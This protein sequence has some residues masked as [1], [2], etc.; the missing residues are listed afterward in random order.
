MADHQ[1]HL[2]GPRPVT[3]QGLR[4]A[5][6]E[7]GLTVPSGRLILFCRNERPAFSGEWPDGGTFYLPTIYLVKGIVYGNCGHPNQVPYITVWQHLVESLPTRLREAFPTIYL[8]DLI[9]QESRTSKESSGPLMT[10][11][12]GAHS[13]TT[14]SQW[15]PL[16]CK[17]WALIQGPREAM[18]NTSCP[19]DT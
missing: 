16:P 4:M 12:F 17:W 9:G 6:R 1:L 5:G 3:L 8:S 14:L 15:M 19:P 18:G 13:L 2:T 10:L 11:T 7:L